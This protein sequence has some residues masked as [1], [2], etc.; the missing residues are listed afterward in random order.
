MKL[1][2][3]GIDEV[4]SPYDTE[5][6]KIAFIHCLLIIKEPFDVKNLRPILRTILIY[7]YGSS[8]QASEGASVHYCK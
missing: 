8:Q 7:E 2:F 4:S 6:T 3:H 1:S 5:R